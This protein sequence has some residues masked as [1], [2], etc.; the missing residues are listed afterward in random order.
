MPPPLPYVNPI[1]AA[2]RRKERD[3]ELS[4]VN[5]NFD[6][7]VSDSVSSI[8]SNS[9]Q[10]IYSLAETTQISTSQTTN[11]V[12]TK[13]H[14]HILNH[15][16]H[17]QSNTQTTQTDLDIAGLSDEILVKQKQLEQL[18]QLKE[19]N[20]LR[21]FNQF[22]QTQVVNNV[23]K[24]TVT[25]ALNNAIDSVVNSQF[26]TSNVKTSKI[27]LSDNNG[28]DISSDHNH[29]QEQVVTTQTKT[30]TT[31]TTTTTSIVLQQNNSKSQPNLTELPSESE[32]LVIPES[33]IDH[34][35][36]QLHQLQ[37]IDQFRQFNQLEQVQLQEILDTM[38][39]CQFVD[40]G[41]E[42]NAN[43]N[44]TNDNKLQ[45]RKQEI[46]EEYN[47][48]VSLLN[49]KKVILLDKYEQKLDILIEKK[50]ELLTKL[51]TL[52][53]QVNEGIDLILF[54]AVR[55]LMPDFI[56]DD[57][58]FFKHKLR[59]KQQLNDLD[60]ML[61][62]Q[63]NREHLVR[64]HQRRQA[65]STKLTNTIKA[66]TASSNYI[67]ESLA[68]RNVKSNQIV[69]DTQIQVDIQLHRHWLRR[70]WLKSKLFSL[71][72]EQRKRIL[73]LSQHLKTLP[74]TVLHEII[75]IDSNESQFSKNSQ[76]GQFDNNCM[77]ID[78]D[79]LEYPMSTSK[80]NPLTVN[81]PLDFD[82]NKLIEGQVP[83][84]LQ[85]A[86]STNT[87]AI[88]PGN[89]NISLNSQVQKNDHHQ[90]TIEDF[91]LAAEHREMHHENQS[92]NFNKNVN[93]NELNLQLTSNNEV[94]QQDEIQNVDKNEKSK[95]NN[96]SS[97]GVNK[98]K[99]NG[100]GYTY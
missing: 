62:M 42:N 97:G 39:Q 85:T 2:R 3:Q 74:V 52:H 60:D 53:S 19:L 24:G 79:S 18:Q 26:S 91:N 81:L 93:I 96:K 11:L 14:N 83:T 32:N 28:N 40:G 89:I 10:S 69:R 80:S 54:A 100:W 23:I 70:R 34:H 95:G 67:S 71:S 65:S 59:L 57:Y 84:P 27:P 6:E 63:E 5:R 94:E 56:L 4:N 36:Q 16:H 12:Q 99:Q 29:H 13:N 61:V 64:E 98:K 8:T 9:I 41:S 17:H 58:K 38:E 1:D 35:Q 92:Q 50:K 87:N 55:G 25:S 49:Y 78:Q 73:L 15:Q 46:I 86:V 82:Y 33:S 45:E 20:Q 44:P 76:F 75:K 31:T 48:K 88:N 21:Q 37:Q 72:P 77:E 66:H 30:T 7:N 68:Y 51:I 43:N 22:Q 90:N 47:K